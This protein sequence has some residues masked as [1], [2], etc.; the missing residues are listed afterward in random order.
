M[1]DYQTQ[2]SDFGM[3][4][5]RLDSCLGQQLPE[6]ETVKIPCFISDKQYLGWTYEQG[7]YMNFLRTQNRVYAPIYNQ[8]EDDIVREIY[9]QIFGNNVSFIESGAISKYGGILHCITW[10]YLAS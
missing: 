8:P 2:D 5:K 9:T 10:N 3:F 1:N 4:I 7:N 6:V